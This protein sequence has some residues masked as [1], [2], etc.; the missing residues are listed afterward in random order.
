MS[1]S[2]PPLGDT[3]TGFSEADRAAF[4][5][6]TRWN[7]LTIPACLA[8]PQQ[9]GITNARLKKTVQA[10]LAL[11][12]D[13]LTR[14]QIAEQLGFKTVET[15]SN[16]L[17]LAGKRGLILP[18]DQIRPLDRVDY[19]LTH[20][21]L[22]RVEEAV[23]GKDADRAQTMAFKVLKETLFK[24][25][26][27]DKTPAQTAPTLLAIKIEQSGPVAP[28]REGSVGGTP[29]YLDGETSEP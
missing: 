17:S 4:H 25:Y 1:D 6:S 7:Q 5:R 14:R 2:R 24:S 10:I 12:L 27:H 15:I 22:D 28:M 29:G 13:G 8:V 21:L 18:K 26:D 23:T 20:K 19:V 16:Y 3:E 11:Q 9:S